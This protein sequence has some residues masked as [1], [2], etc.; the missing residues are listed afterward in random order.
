MRTGIHITII[1]LL[2]AF[3]LKAQ[4]VAEVFKEVNAQYSKTENVSMDIHYELFTNY[5]APLAYE[6]STGTYVKQGSNYYS[7]LLG[8]TTMQNKKYALSVS[9]NDKMIVVSNPVKI[10][11]APSLV[12]TDS[13]LKRCTST[14]VKK[15][16]EGNTLCVLH[17][18]NAPFSE[19][20]RIEME[21]GKN[22]FITRMTLYYREAVNLNESDPQLKKEKPK[23]VISYSNI[24][25]YPVIK[26]GQFSE[27]TFIIDNGDK[28]TG[29][30]AYST[31]RILNHKK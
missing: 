1:T 21:V 29:A 3:G 25:T 17:F 13:L 14:E 18:E 26:A 2:L 6:S 5:S 23:L 24:N 9:E 11:K 12:E 19:F 22:S 10:G 31:Y 20:D 8:I 7:S 28:I 16:T 4:T 30:P 27:R 15:T